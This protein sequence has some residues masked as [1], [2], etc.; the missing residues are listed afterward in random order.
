VA[1]KLQ[2][3]ATVVRSFGETA[4]SETISSESYQKKI[5]G[6]DGRVR[7]GVAV[8]P[9]VGDIV[10]GQYRLVSRLGEGMFGSVY[11]AERTD[12]P[13][14]RVALK[15]IN[16]AVFGDRDHDRELVMLAAATHPNIV[17]LKDHGVTADHIWLT[18]ALYE[19]ETLA[20][21][22]ERGTLDL[23]EA[24][25]I[26]VPIAHGVAALHARG[27]RHQ[28][29]KPENIY[30]ANFAGQLHPVLLDLG[31]A[32]EAHSEFVAGTALFGAPEQV[33]ALAGMGEP[34]ALSERVDTYCLASTLLFALVGEKRFPG[35]AAKTPFDIVNAFTV[36]Q[37]EPVADDAL[38]ELTGEPRKRLI[39]AFKRWLLKDPEAR[40]ETHV[41]AEEL[42]VL[43]EKKR[44]AARAE[45]DRIERQR[46][47]LRRVQL[48][49]AA[50]AVAGLG[51][52]YYG[53]TKRRTIELASELEK[54][55]ADG[56]ASFDQ[57]DTCQAAQDITVRRE[58]ACQVARA[59][60]GVVHAA[61]VATMQT[62]D[63]EAAKQLLI[64][65]NGLKSCEDDAEA[66]ALTCATDRETLTT[67]HDQD[68]TAWA[69]TERQ[70]AQERDEARD[71]EQACQTQMTT[72]ET[73]KRTCE[74]E[75][76]SC[77]SEPT[78][79]YGPVT[80]GPPA[81]TT[82]P[83]APPPPATPYPSEL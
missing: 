60:D 61:A 55:R 37:D 69:E 16:R 39:E 81:T 43:L 54:A 20:E 77:R 22:L 8:V 4:L 5:A 63:H 73:G 52:S 72:L 53:F 57:L 51:L 9:D 38:P 6:D 7:D 1:L 45:T 64:V 58:R 10:G 82:P 76:V 13:E 65:Q 46:T 83:V 42:D 50:I 32:V 25:K 11:V 68:K 66:A 75:L 12:V 59:K 27:L 74:Q 17:E 23:E 30:L 62:Q 18:M 3:K 2:L 31:V 47:T 24:H 34:S 80:K 56:A 67:S 78:D 15:L 33:E 28:D 36:R 44:D 21:R 48:V 14:H 40:P 49:L 71:T 70:L 41:M 79:I 19:G 26:F 35:H 29:I